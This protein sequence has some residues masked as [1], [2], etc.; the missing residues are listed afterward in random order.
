[1]APP[2]WR[3]ACFCPKTHSSDVRNPPSSLRTRESAEKPRGIPAICIGLDRA[4]RYVRHLVIG[5]PRWGHA[6]SAETVVGMWNATLDRRRARAV[7]E[8]IHDDFLFASF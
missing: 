7:P 1:M 4:L 6:A 8:S 2:N 3:S 5:S